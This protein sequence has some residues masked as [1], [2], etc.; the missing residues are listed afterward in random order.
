MHDHGVAVEILNIDIAHRPLRRALRVEEAGVR[1]DDDGIGTHSDAGIAPS[2]FEIAVA[3]D[4]A[5]HLAA[6]HLIHASGAEPAINN[7]MDHRLLA[8]GT[9][10]A[11]DD[12]PVGR[13]M[14][15]CADAYQVDNLFGA[16]YCP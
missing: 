12:A 15:R 5:K 7:G 13:P 8:W 11:T 14:I 6:H 1:W 2:G 3:I 4:I 9:N 16:R 10:E